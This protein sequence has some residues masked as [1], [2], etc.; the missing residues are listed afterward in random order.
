MKTTGTSTG[1][2]SACPS[3]DFTFYGP[4]YDLKKKHASSDTFTGSIV[5][6]H[7]SGYNLTLNTTTDL[8][9]TP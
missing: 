3:S 1:S 7:Y 9:I 8:T 5:A 2:T 6:K 4:M